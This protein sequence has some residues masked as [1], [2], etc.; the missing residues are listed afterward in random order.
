MFVFLDSLSVDQFVGYS[1][2]IVEGRGSAYISGLGE[3]P[4]K[5]NV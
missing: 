5:G 2:R 1:G 4:V 3:L